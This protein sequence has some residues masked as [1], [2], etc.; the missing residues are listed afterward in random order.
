MH[1]FSSTSILS[2]FSRYGELMHYCAC[3]SSVT[4]IFQSFHWLACL[5]RAIRFF[6]FVVTKEHHNYIHPRTHSTILPFIISFQLNIHILGRFRR[7]GNMKL[8]Q[9][10]FNLNLHTFNGTLQLRR[11]VGGD[12]TCNDRTR[13]STSTS[14]SN[15]TEKKPTSR[16]W[17][18]VRKR[19]YCHS[20]IIASPTSIVMSAPSS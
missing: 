16:D 1:S 3:L 7:I 9:K 2:S 6:F 15:F 12:G 8:H 18:K 13:H 20:S 5:E 4:F 14:Q 11:F 19:T 10:L 17:T